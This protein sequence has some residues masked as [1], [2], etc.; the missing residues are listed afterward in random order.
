MT[1]SPAT[2]M[3]STKNDIPVA[4]E[5]ALHQI[6]FWLAPALGGRESSS[7]SKIL[8]ISSAYKITKKMIQIQIMTNRLPSPVMNDEK[9]KSLH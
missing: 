9:R 5:I 8:V 6:N 4:T 7:G 1:I 2:A 3:T